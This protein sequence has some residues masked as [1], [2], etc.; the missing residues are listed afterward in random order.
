MSAL[1]TK[2]RRDLWRLK[3]QVATIALV[4]ACAFMSMLMLRSSWQSLLA[5]RDS[6][7]GQQ[8]FGDVFAKLVRAPDAV[9]QDL[10]A[11][12]GVKLVY[13]RLVQDVMIPMAGEPDPVTG[14]IVSLPD[15]G[16][17]A[18]CGIYLR[19]GRLPQVG[20]VDEAVVLEQFATAHE[21]KLGDRIDVVMEGRL[22]PVQVVGIALSPEFV[23]AMSGR[24]AMPDNRR[25]V[26]LWMSRRGIEP[27]FRMDGAFDDVV[28]QLERTASLPDVLAAVDR[29]LA[30][31][32]GFHAI[33][34]DKQIS[35]FALSSELGMLRTLA[36]VIPTIFLAV[37]AFLVNVVISRLVFLERTQIAV[38]KAL[39][40]TDR[41]IA[42][43]YLA[44]VASVVAI[45][46]LLGISAGARSARWMTDLYADFYSFPTRLYRFDASLVITTVAIGLAAAV[47]GALGAVRRTTRMPP[48]QAMRPPAPLD[49]R[50]SILEV[51]RIDRLVGPSAMMVVREIERRP[52]RFVMSTMGIALGISIFLLGRFSWDSFDHLMNDTFLREHREDLVVSFRRTR[53][54]SAVQELAHLPG[55]EATEGQRVVPV[56]FRAGTHWRDSMIIG[57]PD[58]PL[59]RHVLHRGRTPIALPTEGVVMTDELALRLG[60]R[61]GDMVEAELLEGTWPTRS[62]LVAGL[63]D[64]P[65]GMQAYGSA[66]WLSG[67]LREDPRVSAVL[68]AVEDGRMDA[69]RE[70]LKDLPE[71]IGVSSTS[72]AIEQ[73]RA[74]TGESMLFMT[75]VLTLSAAAIAVGVVYNNARIALSLRSRDLASLR[76]LGFTRSEISGVLLGELALQVIVGI[77]LGLWLGT[78]GSH[79]F[80]ASMDREAFRFPVIIS[81]HTYAVAAV[82]ALVSG[83]ASALLVRRQLDR[84]DLV[85]VLKSSE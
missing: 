71:V 54:A 68:L 3:G 75:I 22:R 16:V 18:L 81:D 55:V 32:G 12:P 13:P 20:S 42:I 5:A 38:L 73:Y 24:E 14:R 77:P 50:R 62:V 43:H 61:V 72:H 79:L 78:W 84:L 59:L 25:F 9:A 26:V 35:N 44:L 57:L 47:L 30:P 6:Y 17:P 83:L 64:E 66:T 52:L 53:P 74:Q 69:V 15:D 85:S 56:R 2:L 80:A 63:V 31:Y 39:G 29:V 46:S 28:L 41:R 1:N 82:I 70:Q 34:R 45:A 23:L 8:R 19:A 21:L 49:Y 67:L 10:V 37:A 33:G 27:V 76:V 40:F 4:L 36:L 60:V 48:A 11:I 58:Q 65:F 7:Y 51:L